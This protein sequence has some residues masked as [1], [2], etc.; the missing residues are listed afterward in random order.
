MIFVH[1]ML[2]VLV[3]K[4]VYNFPS[5]LSCDLTLPGDTLITEYTRC[6]SSWARKTVSL[7]EDF[8]K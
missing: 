4:R 7:S 1:S 6:I 3:S 8:T 2:Q 5:H